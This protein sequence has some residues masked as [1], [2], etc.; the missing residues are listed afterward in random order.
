MTGFGR[1]E[2]IQD[3][4][5]FTIE[6]KSVNHRYCDINVRMPRKISF[7]ENNVRNYIKNKLSRGKVDVYISYEDHSEKKDNIRFNEELTKEYLSHFE[8]ISNTFNLDNDIKV[9]HMTRYPDVLTIEEQQDDEDVL[10]NILSKAIEIAITKMISTRET[11]GELLKKDIIYKLNNMIEELN[12]I[13]EKTPLVVEEYKLKLESRINE[14]MDNVTI[15]ESRLA[16]EVAVFADKSCID[17]EIVRLESHIQ[18]F[19]NTFDTNQPIGRK[20]DFLAQ[21]MNRE[22]NTILSKANSINISNQAIELKTEIE[23]IREQIQNIE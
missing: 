22:A 2:Y 16:M 9:S 8:Y 23:K 3:D 6:I 20:L 13:K 21:E 1:G 12:I 18:H 10:W 14:L 7:L 4:R 5:K 11:E 19:K 15:D 17:E